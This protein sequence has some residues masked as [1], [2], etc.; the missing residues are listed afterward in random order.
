MQ[1]TNLSRR[2]LF[3]NLFSQLT[4]NAQ[5]KD[6]LFEKYSRK[7]FNGRRS[8]SF[9]YK[10][11]KSEFSRGNEQLERVR[12]V[13]SGL[14]QYTGN[15]TTTEALHLLRRTGF[16]VK[17]SHVD[18]ITQLD[19][20]TAINTVLNVITY[21]PPPINSYDIRPDFYDTTGVPYGADWTNSALTNFWDPVI[22]YG[23]TNTGR[24]IS[25][26]SWQI[27][28]V[29]THDVTIREKMTQFWYHIMPVSVDAIQDMSRE[30]LVSN[31][32]RLLYKYMKMFRDN[33]V[34][35]FKTLIETMARM[36][37]MAVYLNNEINSK[38]APDENFARE[39]ME[40]FTLG[41]DSA[42]TYTQED[43]VQ[44]AKLLT[45]WRIQDLTTPNESVG[46]VPE[47]HDYS[48]KQFS[49]F[50]NNTVIPGTGADELDAFIDMIFTKSEIISKYICR[51][52][53]RFFV[54]YDIDSYIEA[55][56][57]APLAEIFVNNNWQ[58][59]PVLEKLFKSQH[60][61]DMANRGVYIKSPFDL[62]LGTIRTFN[63]DFRVA[64][65]EHYGAQYDIYS[66]FNEKCE[67]INQS[68]VRV[69]NVSGWP[70][71]YQKPNFHENWI[72]SDTI[73]RRF[74]FIEALVNGFDHRY[75][76]YDYYYEDVRTPMEIDVI[77]FV[78]Q[79]GNEI[80]LDPNRLIDEC[81]KYLL[82]VDLSPTH[83]NILKIQTLLSDQ[84]SD[85]Y[86][87]NA[88]QAY[89]TN[90]EDTEYINAVKTRLKNMLYT[91]LQYAEY[92]LM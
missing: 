8:S 69:V 88:W 48:N 59:K 68:M 2:A 4:G 78:Q 72:N 13:I 80:C 16:G 62:Y 25:L 57:I 55:N 66:Y 7:V 35:N 29:L 28:L 22:P 85:Y 6:P 46:F 58:I 50:F 52:L 92:Q 76:R 71:F 51:R 56:V 90:P 17:K 32:A 70:A 1:N 19:F 27:E 82:P 45:G 21:V 89:T 86:W 44:A 5:K 20:N 38:T 39:I 83:K 53:Y 63:V 41:K 79:F 60:F 40:L 73:Q 77:A 75:G 10:A 15:W 30:H 54:Y 42:T 31:S 11:R 24:L 87:T 84:T 74:K 3:G 9:L 23:N 18:N 64:N 81:I 26:K 33:S 12:P 91:I 37:A 65:P 34:G 43:V 67:E 47:Y 49:S 36:P 61:F 14:A